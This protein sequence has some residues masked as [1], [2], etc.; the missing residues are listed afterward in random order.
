MLVAIHALNP[1]L[2]Q[3]KWS[4]AASD[5]GLSKTNQYEVGMAVSTAIYLMQQGYAPGQLAILTPYL[6]QLIEIQQALSRQ[7]VGVDVGDRD[8]KELA[9]AAAS[10][11]K[12]DSMAPAPGG[13]SSS[14][15]KGTAQPKKASAKG[16]RVATIDNFQVCSRQAA[17]DIWYICA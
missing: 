1:G 7:A 4:Q 11:G 17:A 12:A 8:V 5:H 2:F 10:D 14:S 3:G 13:S 16:V 15:S 6:G 9:A